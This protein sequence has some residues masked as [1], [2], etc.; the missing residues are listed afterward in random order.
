MEAFH[1]A[2]QTC[3]LQQQNQ[4]SSRTI[5]G[6]NRLLYFGCIP[7]LEAWGAFMQAKKD[8]ADLESKSKAMKG[9]LAV[10]EE[11]V[12]A[13]ETTLEAAV[14]PIGNLVHDSVPVS[15]DEVSLL[16][17]TLVESSRYAALYLHASCI[18]STLRMRHCVH[19][20]VTSAC[21]EEA[22]PFEMSL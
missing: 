9:K 15:N 3:R 5:I 21:L 8:S 10:L 14:Q 16:T 18:V 7:D 1:A 22:R 12:K 13:A 11:Q 19:V 6:Q 20:L 4:W 2:V 17:S